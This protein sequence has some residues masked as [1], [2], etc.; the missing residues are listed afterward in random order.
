MR[1]EQIITLAID[2]SIP[3]IFVL[4]GFAIDYYFLPSSSHLFGHSL[5]C[6]LLISLGFANLPLSNSYGKG[7]KW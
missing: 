7:K 1:L 3:P 2:Y 5:S 6:L 4:S